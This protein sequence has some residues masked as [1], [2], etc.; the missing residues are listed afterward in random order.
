MTREEAFNI[1]YKYR[2]HFSYWEGGKALLNY[3]WYSQWWK[4]VEENP[5]AH[6]GNPK[7]FDWVTEEFTSAC[8][9]YLDQ[10]GRDNGYGK[11][12]DKGLMSREEMGTFQKELDDKIYK[13][14]QKERKNKRDSQDKRDKKLLNQ[15]MEFLKQMKPGEV[16]LVKFGRS[17]WPNRGILVMEIEEEE[18]SGFY[19]DRVEKEVPFNSP[20]K[21]GYVYSKP[22]QRWYGTKYAP[23][24]PKF[25]WDGQTF[26]RTK[27]YE[28]KW[29]KFIIG[30]VENAIVVK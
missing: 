29:C 18:I 13:Q 26:K 28:T 24:G 27:V 19:L 6:T 15:G 12:R 8:N 11:D 4:W 7:K 22:I 9:W 16:W 5:N 2:K 1:F 25:E 30:K 23:I 20:E 17:M 3:A 14:H 10:V 21:E